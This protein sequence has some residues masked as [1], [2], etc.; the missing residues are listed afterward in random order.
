MVDSVLDRQLVRLRV[1]YAASPLRRFLVWWSGELLAL[2]PAR[3][4]AWLTERR[5]EVCARLE[6]GRIVLRHQD[7]E[8]VELSLAQDADALR[9]AI[10]RALQRGEET[11]DVV[12]CL[13]AGRLLRRTLALPAAAEENL[14]QVLAFE[15]DRQ[16]PFKADQV[17]YDQRVVARDP[18]A[19]QVRIE[20]ALVPRAAVDPD[21]ATIASA[22]LPLDV[23]DG[24]DPDTGVRYGFN[25]LPP[26]RR[27]VRPNVWLR[28]NLAL[29][30]VALVLVGLVMAQLVSNREL[31]LEQLQAQTDKARAE[32]RS[33][34]TLRASLKEAI[35]G[36]NFLAQRKR[37]RPVV[38]DL[39]LDITRRLNNDTWL[40][41]FSLNGDQVQV[42]GQSKEAAS[43]IT[44]L[45]KS[46][47][48]EAPALQGAITPDARTGKEQFLIAAKAKTPEAAPAPEGAPAAPKQPA[49]A[50][51][52]GS[53]ADAAAAQ[54]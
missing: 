49:P 5:E 30:A 48:L 21:L 27:A 23:V 47:L 52:P 45:Q 20:L 7:G 25:L 1:A 32:A 36:A 15:M 26:E 8:A 29:G 6:P 12:Y 54:R 31:A 2:L 39:L 53:S 17:Y 9:A 18:V 4:R 34:A 3:V 43:L 11:P 24:V 37:S 44:I 51:A 35:E 50:P 41:R 14:R 19:K 33:V 10:A 28:L 42:Q 16:T 38:S 40:Q 46:P 22:G 13:P